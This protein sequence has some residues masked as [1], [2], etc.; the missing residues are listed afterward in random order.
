[1][2]A[3]V[4]LNVFIINVFVGLL[5]TVSTVIINGV[6]EMAIDSKMLQRI[7]VFRLNGQYLKKKTTDLVNAAAVIYWIF[8]MMKTV[9]IYRFVIEGLT[10]FFTD[11]ITLGSTSF[12]VGGIFIF[13][14]VIW[15]STVISK[16]IRAIL[17]KDVLNKLSLGKG[18]P[19]TI[20][21]MV[22]YTLVT[23][24]VFFAVSVAG[25]PMTSLTLLIGAFGVGIGFGLQNIFNNLVSGLILLF[26]RPIQIDDTIEVGTL[27]GKVK[28][29]GI[30]SSHVRTFDGAE[31][32]VPNGNLISNE[33]VNWTLSDQQRRIEVIAGV[34]YGSDPHM[35]QKLFM[36]EL[37]KHPDIIQNPLPQVYFQSLGESSLDFRLLFWTSNFGD[38]LRIQSDIVFKVHDILKENNI[39]I[40]FPQRDLHLR[41]VDQSIVIKN[42]K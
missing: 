37:E 31:V 11:E 34:A 20:S 16:I 10:S 35:V 22:G 24:G 6:V 30:R 40:P 29:M 26:E 33:V 39:E 12:T 9:N 18:V 1:M 7:N 25:I 36:N 2:L 19:R 23:L 41:S 14:F 32:I 3:E 42:E 13:F 28:S 4:T 5:L 21:V 38:W 8:I 17:E 15:S 27:I